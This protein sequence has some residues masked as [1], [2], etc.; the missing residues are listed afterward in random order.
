MTEQNGMRAD[1]TKAVVPATVLVAA[2]IFTWRIST[3]MSDV[4]SSVR[5]QGIVSDNKFSKVS[6][7]ISKIADDIKEVRALIDRYVTESVFEAWIERFRL[8][9]VNRTPDSPIVIPPLR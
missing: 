1:L 9:N 8:S 4:T 6:D 5:E 7:D 2:M 3:N